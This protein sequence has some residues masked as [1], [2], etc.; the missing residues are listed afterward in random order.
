MS[1]FQQCVE[2][3]PDGG[4]ALLQCIA[5]TAEEVRLRSGSWILFRLSAYTY[6]GRKL[7]CF[8]CPNKPDFGN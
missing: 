7:T 4:D 5:D 3:N 2:L 8:A 1:I 6:D